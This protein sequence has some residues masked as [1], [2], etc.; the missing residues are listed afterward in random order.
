MDLALGAR[1]SA[2]EGWLFVLCCHPTASSQQIQWP[3][4]PV[5]NYSCL[6]KLQRKCFAAEDSRNTIVLCPFFPNIA[7][8]RPCTHL[9]AFPLL[10]VSHLAAHSSS[11]VQGLVEVVE[12]QGLVELRG[13]SSWILTFVLMQPL[14]TFQDVGGWD[15]P[16]LTLTTCV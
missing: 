12:V 14:V 15:S 2:S 13:A 3:L 6:E 1:P 16:Q 10:R 11:G 9:G 5:L 7:I 4:M 8:I